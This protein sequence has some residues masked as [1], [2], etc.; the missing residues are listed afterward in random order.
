MHILMYAYRIFL[1]N[2]SASHKINN[3]P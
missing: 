3:T 2:R 1:L